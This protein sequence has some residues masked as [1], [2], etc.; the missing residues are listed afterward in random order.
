MITITDVSV[1][2]QYEQEKSQ[3]RLL[4]IINATVSHELRNPLNS[5]ISINL[6]KEFLYQQLRNVL[7]STFLDKERI[8][9]QAQNL[10]KELTSSLK[11]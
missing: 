4:Q 6:Q 5:I 3:N 10:M 7:S 8:I 9:E 1:Q 2:Y 11:I